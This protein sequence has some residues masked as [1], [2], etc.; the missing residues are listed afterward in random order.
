MSIF[1]C[2]LLYH[3]TL[4]FLSNTM[5][6]PLFFLI[7]LITYIRVSSTTNEISKGFFATPNPSIPTFQTLLTDS[8][9]NFSLGFLRVNSSQ[10]A[11][12]IIH[13]PS[14]DPVWHANTPNPAR[15]AQPTR[16][17]FNGSLIL[18]DPDSGVFWSSNS[19]GGDRLLLSNANLQIFNAVTLLWQSFDFPTD[20]LLQDQN[21]T[22]PMSLVSSNAL[23]SMRVIHDYLGLYA[24]FGGGS[25]QIYWKRT[26]MEAK[27][28]VVSGMGP[29]YARISSDGFL[30]LYQ[31]EAAPVDVIAFG[32]FQRKVTGL[33]RARLESDGNLRGYFWNFTKWVLDFE[34]IS[35][36][37][38]LPSGC[39]PYG[40]CTYGKGCTCLD[41][42]TEFNCFTGANLDLCGEEKGFRVL[43]RMGIDLPFKELMGF[44]K[45]GSLEECEGLCQQ[46]CSCFGAVYNNVSGFCYV[47]DYPIQTVVGVGD[48]RK[49]GIF[50]VGLVERK[51]GVGLGVLGVTLLAV[52][53]GV[54][55]GCVVFGV[56]GFWR[57]KEEKICEGLVGEEG[58][59]PGPYRNLGESSRWI[60]LSKR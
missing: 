4:S 53:V 33:R 47:L 54:L 6:K 23:Y 16:L 49:V 45:V 48:V 12:T 42:Q 27:A 58:S 19:N 52:V 30:G 57:K 13:V 44:E 40:V 29:I 14:S 5:N 50:K 21:F 3:P 2:L 35:D 43:K 17:S 15:W 60:E 55:V 51:K 10:L 9:N 39:G 41:N 59:S 46:N 1:Q 28:Q 22:L 24:D 32:S 31:T 18:S 34:A 20:T 25:D 11:L 38:E 56:Y 37:C 7:F 36:T 26:P 8:T